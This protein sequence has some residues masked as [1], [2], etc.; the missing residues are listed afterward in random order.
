[1]RNLL[2]NL[3]HHIKLT[4]IALLAMMLF[5]LTGCAN[6]EQQTITNHFTSAVNE[7]TQNTTDTI[8]AETE[9]LTDQFDSHAPL[10]SFEDVAQY[11]REHQQLPPNYITKE[12]AR[13]LG[14]EASKGNLHIV[15]P[16]MS[17]GGDRFG[18][19]EGL[20]PKKQGRIWYEADIDYE[21]GT[22]NAKRIVFSNDG[23]IYMTT[24]HYATFTDITEEGSV[25]FE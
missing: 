13:K 8:D 23:L 24:D 1:M 3:T 14:W 6:L 25:K 12:E 9:T 4:T 11:I 20:L 15:A 7:A 2:H 16:G 19:R 10:T 5:M 21:K 22:R 18:N 17:I